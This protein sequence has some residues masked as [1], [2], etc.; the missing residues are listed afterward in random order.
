MDEFRS[1]PTLFKE[2]LNPMI[3]SESTADFMNF[4]ISII[5]SNQLSMYRDYTLNL[6]EGRVVFEY[7]RTGFLISSTKSDKVNVSTSNKNLLE[8][9][10]KCEA[11]R[12][13][14]KEIRGW[15]ELNCEVPIYLIDANSVI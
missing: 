5:T 1:S 2:V 8:G 3:R 15:R 4:I 12:M 6:D 13:I 9:L 7:R 14:K 10:T 11:F